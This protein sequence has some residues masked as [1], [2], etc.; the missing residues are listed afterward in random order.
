MPGLVEPV[1]NRLLPAL[2]TA[3]GVTLLAAGVLSFSTPVTAVGTASPTPSASGTAAPS[4]PPSLATLPP[5]GSAVPSATPTAP[6]DRVATRVRIAA[7]QVD[8]PVIEQ[9]TNKVPCNVALYFEDPF[10][11]QP[12]QGRATY[13]Y[14]HAQK[15]MFLPILDASKV[16]NGKKMLGMVVEVWTN[17]DQHFLYEVTKVKRHVPF[18]TGLSDALRATSEELWLQTSEGVGTAPKLQLLAKPLSHGSAD[19]DEANPTAKPVACP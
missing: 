6:P 16:N 2:L 10:L 1:R 7:L 13:L 18:D 14:A 15:G 4:P 19:H 12:G 8:L 11:G 9:T 17:D 5:I 3:V